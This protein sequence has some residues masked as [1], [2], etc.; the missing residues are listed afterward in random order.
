MPLVKKLIRLGKSSRAVVI[1]SEWLSYYEKQ[2]LSIESILMELNGEIT[3]RVP[4][5]AEG[6]MFA[7]EAD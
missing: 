5:E 3:M 6:K 7:K 2:G 1:P 4:T